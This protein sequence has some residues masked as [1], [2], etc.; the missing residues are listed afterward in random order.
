MA[1]LGEYLGAGSGTTKL[2]LRL[3]GNST[4]T[5][6]NSNSGTDTAITYS[7]ANGKF[8]QGAGFNGTTSKIA[9]NSTIVLGTGDFTTSL[10][11]NINNYPGVGTLGHLF[12]KRDDSG[13][14]PLFDIHIDSSGILSFEGRITSTVYSIIAPSALSKNVY[15]NIQIIRSGSNGYMY[16]NGTLFASN[17]TTFSNL[18]FNTTVRTLSLGCKDSGFGNEGF[19][20][21]KVDEVIYETTAWTAQKVQK[22]YTTSRGRFGIT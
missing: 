3:N 5:S 11:V 21:G 8:G 12:V 6:G 4:D 15:H 17:T 20:D 18:D 7:Q 9:I 16:L 13:P 22:Y 19:L 14:L 1:T 10:W 2:L